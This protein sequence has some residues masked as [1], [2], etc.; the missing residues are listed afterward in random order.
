MPDRF[1]DPEP[2]KCRN[3]ACRRGWLGH[4][5]EGRPIPCPDCKPH[6]VS[7]TPSNDN[8][9]RSISARAQAAI[10]RDNQ[11]DKR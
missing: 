9:G 4:D 7:G 2:A 1:G 10:E 5:D 8:A 11:G 3:P 6:L